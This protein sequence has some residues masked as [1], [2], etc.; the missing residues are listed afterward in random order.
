M[1]VF[2]TRY[3]DILWVPVF[4]SKGSN[5][6][7]NMGQFLPIYQFFGKL[8]FILTSLYIVFIMTRG[9]SRTREREKAWKLG[10]WCLGGA[11]ILC[12]PVTAIFQNYPLDNA[13]DFK[14]TQVRTY[15]YALS[16]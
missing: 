12:V 2:I 16:H 13:Y 1:L 8:F 9:Y 3:L 10:M 14:F 7:K 4:V 5:A 11:A 6:Y 15:T